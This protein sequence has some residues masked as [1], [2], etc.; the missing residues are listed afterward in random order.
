MI[1]TYL[2]LCIAVFVIGSF[3]FTSKIYNE[4]IVKILLAFSGSFLL[5]ISMLHL[6]PEVYEA[7][8]I[9]AGYFVL[10]GFIIQLL[11]EILSKGIEHGHIHVHKHD[12]SF[13]YGVFIGL[14][15]HSLL[16]GMPI[17]LS[18]VEVVGHNHSSSLLTGIFLH[19]LPIAIVL[20]VL[21]AKSGVSKLKGI[22]FL[23]LF[24]SSMPLGTFISYVLGSTSLPIEHY[25]PL[26]LGLVIG[27]FLHV[28]TTILFEASEN[29]R[30]NLMKFLSIL[31]GIFV[32]ILSL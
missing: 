27:I 8:G 15:F 5:A 14:S 29:H 13:P 28:S 3:V 9:K 6:L 32:A 23:L 17:D 30:F 7:A 24:A 31:F 18:G 22:L 20:G 10:A 25:Y 16:E 11:I 2:L 19:K 4:K 21:F 12:H 1:L 26:V